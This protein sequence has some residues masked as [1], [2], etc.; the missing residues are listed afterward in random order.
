V[1]NELARWIATFQQ[2]H[3]P[4]FLKW[5]KHEGFCIDG[6]VFRGS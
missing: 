6:D 1:V 5:R 2:T 3:T 4:A